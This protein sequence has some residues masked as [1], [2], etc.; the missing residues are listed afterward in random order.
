MHKDDYCEFC[1]EFSGGSRNAFATLYGEK[2]ASRTLLETDHVRV[3]PSL[4]HFVKGY[5]LLVTK[6]HFCALADIPYEAIREVEDLKISL[7]Q[8]LQLQYGPYVFFE[9]GA[10][11][12]DSGGCGIYHAHLHAVPLKACNVLPKLQDQF[13]HRPIESMSDLKTAE[14]SKSYLYYEDSAG[15]SWLFFPKALPSQYL[16]RLIAESAGISQWDWR[17]SGREDAL[18]ATRTE[19]LSTLSAT[20]HD[21]RPR[22]S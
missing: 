20:H 3:L 15:H 8:R 19:V 10:R 13:P 6:V 14:P 12:V 5:L 9:H 1:D 7:A 22:F 16:R 2:L 17:R 18:L 4:G 11:T 21:R